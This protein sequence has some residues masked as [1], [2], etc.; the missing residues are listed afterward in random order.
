MI[1]LNKKQKRIAYRIIIS[2][3]F[4]IV[5]LIFF[6]FIYQIS[7]NN[8]LIAKLLPILLWLG[9]YIFVGFDLIKKGVKNLINKQLLGEDFLMLIA[10][11]GAF[12]LGIYNLFTSNN[13]EGFEEAVAKA[14]KSY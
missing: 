12:G 9:L 1:N 5:F 4:F 3:F 7:A 14:L 2:L 13:A 10:S 6:R 8:Q 11:L